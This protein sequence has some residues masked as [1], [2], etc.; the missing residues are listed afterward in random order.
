[1]KKTCLWTT[2]LGQKWPRCRVCAA[3][4][5][6]RYVFGRVEHVLGM[7]HD[8]IYTK[9]KLIIFFPFKQKQKTYSPN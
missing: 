5:R 6:P 1:M 8:F 4:L 3:S 9:Q 2:A 7:E